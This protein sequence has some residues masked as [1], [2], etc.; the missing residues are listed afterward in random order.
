MDIR[1]TPLQE[2]NGDQKRQPDATNYNSNEELKVNARH[3]RQQT[4]RGVPVSAPICLA[5]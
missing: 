5:R 3:Q 2:G 1:F 4:R